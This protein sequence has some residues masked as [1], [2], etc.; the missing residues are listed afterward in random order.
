MAEKGFMGKKRI[1]YADVA[2]QTNDFRVNNNHIVTRNTQ[3]KEQAVRTVYGPIVFFFFLSKDANKTRSK[4]AIMGCNKPFP[5]SC[6]HSS[7]VA[8]WTLTLISETKSAG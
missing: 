2:E 1:A 6:Y 5:R 8:N 4:C 7:W 3:T